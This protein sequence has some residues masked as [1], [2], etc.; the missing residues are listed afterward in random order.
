[1]ESE[2][3]NGNYNIDSNL[4]QI[5]IIMSHVTREALGIFKPNPK[6]V[7]VAVLCKILIP[8]SCRVSLTIPEWRNVMKAKFEALTKNNTWMLI[9]SSSDD[10][11]INTKWVFKIK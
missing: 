10:N 11:V 4:W 3:S 1:M 7:L 9:P 5:L 8:K 6:Y 2:A